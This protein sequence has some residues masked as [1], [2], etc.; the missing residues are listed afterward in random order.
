MPFFPNIKFMGC[1]FYFY[2]AAIQKARVLFLYTVSSICHL[3]CVRALLYTYCEIID[4][5]ITVFTVHIRKLSIPLLSRLKAALS[6]YT[7]RFLNRK[8]L[9]ERPINL[10]ATHFMLELLVMNSLVK[11]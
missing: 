7:F 9:F 5:K 11:I 4:V 8:L 10:Q 6:I 2:C 1:P 3:V